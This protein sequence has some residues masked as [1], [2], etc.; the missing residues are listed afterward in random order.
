MKNCENYFLPNTTHEVLKLLN[1]VEGSVSILAG[2]TDLLIDI[3]QGRHSP[4]VNLVDISEVD[5]FNQFELREKSI[6]I[7]AAVTHARINV[8]EIIQKHAEGLGEACGLV[9]SP[10]VRNVAT[11][12]GNVAH[13]LPAA[14]GTIALMALDAK[15]EIASLGDRKIIPLEELFLGPG[16][17]IL[18]DR[19]EVIIGFHLPLSEGIQASAFKRIMR[20]QGVAIAILNCAVW[21][22]R[23]NDLIE[24]IRISIGPS[25][26]TPRKMSQA[27]CLLKN[28][29]LCDSK[30][31]EAY[32]AVLEDARF[33]TSKHRAGKVYR[34]KMANNLLRDALWTAWKRTQK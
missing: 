31:D 17:T 19:K 22:Q 9:G 10:A 1:E 30:I 34:Q 18:V 23:K 33:R 8:S 24:D 2:G 27:E 6:F 13:A 11:L 26:P 21:L 14:D 20:P 28:Q 3:R 15:V 4:V 7:G 25:G 12:G 32:Q 5:E 29:E 16:K